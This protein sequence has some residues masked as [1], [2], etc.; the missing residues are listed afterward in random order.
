MLMDSRDKLEQKI[1]YL[2]L[3]PLQERWSLVSRAEEHHWSSA[4]LC[5]EGWGEF[6][7]LTYY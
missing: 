5:E 3:N 7:A 2:H 1:D 6:G 4:K